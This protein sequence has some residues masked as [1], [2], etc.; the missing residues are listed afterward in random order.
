LTAH[1]CGNQRYFAVPWFDACLNLRLPKL[2]GTP[3][4]S[5]PID[6]AWL[7]YPFGLGTIIASHL[8]SRLILF[9]D[10]VFA[11]MDSLI[12]RALWNF[13]QQDVGLRS[14]ARELAE[15]ARRAVCVKME[16]DDEDGVAGTVWP[17]E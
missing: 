12:E 1:E 15:S 9:V 2:S 11:T 14:R 5:M 6:D 7:A 4:H 3:L 13:L 8:R 10:S 17:A 16:P